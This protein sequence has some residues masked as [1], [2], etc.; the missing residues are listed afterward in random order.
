[1]RGK[2]IAAVQLIREFGITPAYAG[3][4]PVAS[5][6]QIAERDHPRVCGEKSIARDGQTTRR[7]SPPRMR[8][9]VKFAVFPRHHY[10]DHPRVCG[11]KSFFI[12]S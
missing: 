6:R 10:G 8:G 11:E 5:S 1:M 12:K 4:R 3:K 2:V 9:K 7:G